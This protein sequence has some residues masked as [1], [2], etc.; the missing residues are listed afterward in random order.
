MLRAI[1]G[2][3]ATA[4]ALILSPAS[5]LAGDLTPAEIEAELVGRQLVWWEDGGW[6]IG[7]LTLGRDGT[8]ELFVDRPQRQADVGRWTLRGDELC[9]VWSKMRS[10]QKCYSVKRGA[11]G[12]FLTSGGNVFEIPEIGV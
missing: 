7:R 12:R 9:T 11:D 5:A 3:A 6:L 2:A 4:A 10:A 8:A 1:V